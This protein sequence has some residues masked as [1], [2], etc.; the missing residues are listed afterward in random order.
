MDTGN[1]MNVEDIMEFSKKN[2]NMQE[3]KKIIE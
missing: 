3:L 2:I 1:A